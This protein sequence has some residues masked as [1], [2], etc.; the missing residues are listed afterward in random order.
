MRIFRVAN[1][2]VSLTMIMTMTTAP[3]F[4]GYDSIAGIRL[5]VENVVANQWDF[6]VPFLVE[7][8]WHF[9]VLDKLSSHVISVHL[10]RFVKRH[11]TWDVWVFPSQYKLI[12]VVLLE[13]LCSWFASSRSSPGTC[14]IRES[15]HVFFECLGSLDSRFHCCAIDS[16][17]LFLQFRAGSVAF[18]G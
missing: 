13:E 9:L 18:Q 10:W 14:S 3:V 15:S 6:V 4:R 7:E 16:Y 1:S 12:Q 5:G 2:T 8:C 17:S 11:D